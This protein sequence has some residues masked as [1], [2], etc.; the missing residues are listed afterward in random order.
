MTNTRTLDVLEAAFRK[1][2]PREWHIERSLTFAGI[3]PDF[4]LVHP[5]RGVVV[6]AVVEPPR[7]FRF[8]SYDYDISLREKWDS[9]SDEQKTLLGTTPY[10]PGWSGQAD[11]RDLLLD[12]RNEFQDYFSGLVE[13]DQRRLLRTVLVVV[14]DAEP[15]ESNKVLGFVGAQTRSKLNVE[16]INTSEK[17]IETLDSSSFVTRVVPQA[18]TEEQPMPDYIWSRLKR[19]V[20]GIEDAVMGMAPPPD[21]KF[22]AQQLRILEYLSTPG[23]KRFRGPAGSGKTLIIARKVADAVQRGERVLVV[24]YNKTMCQMIS[25]RALFFLNENVS[26][27]EQRI[28]NTRLFNELTFI[29]WQDRWWARVCSATGLAKERRRI[30][31]SSSSD[32]GMK[33]TDD[34]TAKLYVE[35]RIPSLVLRGL[36]SA[37][38]Y[39]RGRLFYDLVF[40]DEAQ[41]MFP[42][43]WDCLK[44]AGVP[45]TSTIVAVS[46]PTQSMYGSRPWTDQRMKGFSNNPWR[47][48]KASYRL[49]DDYLA[50]V[51][52]FLKKFP[53]D[54]EIIPPAQAEQRTPS[55]STL[56]RISPPPGGFPRDAI[57]AA[58]NYALYTLNFLP[59]QIV[60]LV[61][62]NVR[63][64]AVVRLLREQGIEVSHT[65]EERNRPSFGTTDNV[66]G[67]TFHSYAGWESPCVIFDTGFSDKQKNTNGLLYSGLTRLARRDIGSAMIIVET[68]NQYRGLIRQYCEEIPNQ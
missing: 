32:D 41:N 16:W 33:F 63:G 5:E 30:Y 55:S 25:T 34:N 60:F 62:T 1:V 4:L 45:N 3:T 67:S 12:W 28:K 47:Q 40:A 42:D 7:D 23:L 11:P 21:F 39:S 66:R 31:A 58:I 35:Q 15:E 19:E 6:V 18:F 68:D 43:N 14:Q 53:P 54:D 56:F 24:V 61:P 29:T 46:D 17:P 37:A 10:S 8:Q 26:D 52:E 13:R 65:F 27:V 22:D 38:H 59:H 44:E 51:G 57:A 49:P 2:L 50:F 20:L 64:N 9:L 36:K 48:M